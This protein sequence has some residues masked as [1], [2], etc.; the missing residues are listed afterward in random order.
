MTDEEKKREQDKQRRLNALGT[1]HPRCSCGETRWERFEV[2]H[3]GGQA[4]DNAVIIVCGSCHRTLTFAQKH[5]P[6]PAPSTE[7]WRLPIYHL[8][9][10]AADILRLVEARFLEVAE[11]YATTPAED[12]G[13]PGR[14]PSGWRLRL[15]NLQHGAAEALRIISLLLISIADG[16]VSPATHSVQVEV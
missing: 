13:P 9:Y 2:H 4:H 14:D 8:L 11:E 1:A 12:G 3:I 16:L 5:R 6:A 7:P 10:G 15:Y